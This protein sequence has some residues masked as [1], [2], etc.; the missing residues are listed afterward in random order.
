[1][2]VYITT[3]LSFGKLG[4]RQKR[5][6]IRRGF[7]RKE[8]KN[9]RRTHHE[10][11]PDGTRDTH[12]LA[13][14]ASHSQR[15]PAP[16]SCSVPPCSTNFALESVCSCAAANGCV[17]APFWLTTCCWCGG[18]ELANRRGGGGAEAHGNVHRWLKKQPEAAFSAGSSA[19]PASSP[20][21]PAACPRS[22]L[23]SSQNRHH[24][25]G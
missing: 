11:V 23:L 4:E 1:M 6:K 25:G 5:R 3:R 14:S 15:R 21:A 19:P 22:M 12:T 18:R 8:S 17:H 7:K 16:P 24:A 10:P 20:A 13:V 2:H 9:A